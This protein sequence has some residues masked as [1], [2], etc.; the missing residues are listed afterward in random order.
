MAAPRPVVIFV[1]A[2]EQYALQAFEAEALDYLQKPFSDDRL[3]AVVRR[4]KEQVR[5]RRLKEWSM[6]AWMLYCNVLALSR[7][8]RPWTARW[9]QPPPLPPDCRSPTGT[10]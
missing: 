10:G 7:K 9:R 6:S 4:G 8:C 1:T 3:A 5:Q 2:Y